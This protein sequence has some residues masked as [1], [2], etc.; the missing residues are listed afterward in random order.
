MLGVLKKPPNCIPNLPA[1]EISELTTEICDLLEKNNDGRLDPI[2][3]FPI[4]EVKLQIISERYLSQ[5][6]KNCLL[7]HFSQL[8][9]TFPEFDNK[10]FVKE[11]VWYF[12]RYLAL[13]GVVFKS[14]KQQGKRY[15][16][17]EDAEKKPVTVGDR[18]TGIVLYTPPSHPFSGTGSTGLTG[19]FKNLVN[20]T[21]L[22]ASIRFWILSE[23]L[24]GNVF[25]TFGETTLA[26]LGIVCH[27]G[28]DC[29]PFK[30]VS[31]VIP[32]FKSTEIIF[33]A[34]TNQSQQPP[35]LSEEM[36]TQFY[37]TFCN[38][39]KKVTSDPQHDPQQ[40]RNKILSSLFGLFL[41][42]IID[43]KQHQDL[44]R[45][46]LQFKTLEAVERACI[47]DL[48]ENFDNRIY[49]QFFDCK[50]TRNKIDPITLLNA[51]AHEDLATRMKALSELRIFYKN[52]AIQKKEKEE[53]RPQQ[54]FIHLSEA[55]NSE[56]IKCIVCWDEERT[57]AC[58]PCGHYVLCRDCACDLLHKQ[59]PIC[60]KNV[61]QII[62]IF[63]S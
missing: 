34:L 22:N 12:N 49:T 48:R 29:S 54:K 33:R 27:S 9:P 59:C 21:A 30:T 36:F 10:Y 19:F 53:Y 3:F 20:S 46:I 61:D 39:Q 42:Q 15:I 25:E 37:A 63:N 62:K 2:D 44:I 45:I 26:N 8:L 51:I 23:S 6:D 24:F 31:S 5:I 41:I 32:C 47:K 43:S 7:R 16:R 38:E 40:F 14:S 50:V 28:K 17:C 58:V 1:T 60:R 11:L 4:L 18:S 52:I 35:I 57:H 55:Q 13:K 56:S